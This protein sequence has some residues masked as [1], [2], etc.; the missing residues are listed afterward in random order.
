V[1]GKGSERQGNRQADGEWHAQGVGV[2]PAWAVHVSHIYF[3]GGHRRG[4][5]EGGPMSELRTNPDLLN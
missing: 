3:L 2:A 1:T 5:G 4:G